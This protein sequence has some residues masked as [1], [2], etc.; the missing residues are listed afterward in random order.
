MSVESAWYVYESPG[1]QAVPENW[2]LLGYIHPEILPEIPEIFF[3][4]LEILVQNQEISK[5]VRQILEWL[6][7]RPDP[8]VGVMFS[9]SKG[10][11]DRGHH[12]RVLLPLDSMLDDKL[13][14]CLGVCMYYS[15]VSYGDILLLPLES[16]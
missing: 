16:V 8:E 11:D 3:R 14:D 2:H 9:S 5:S 7:P 4:N 15:I 1:L 12:W 13:A 10:C 6:T